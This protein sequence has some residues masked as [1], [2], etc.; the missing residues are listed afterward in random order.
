M[1]MTIM[2]AIAIRT[3]SDGIE[4][5]YCCRLRPALGL[6]AMY[7]KFFIMLFSSACKDTSLE[8]E[9][10]RADRNKSIQKPKIKNSAI[11]PTKG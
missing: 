1:G 2:I 3:D 5:R 10:Y 7:S 4:L 11:V 9:I 8:S 6:L